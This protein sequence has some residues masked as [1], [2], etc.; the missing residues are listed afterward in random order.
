M[1]WKLLQ[2]ALATSGSGTLA[3]LIGNVLSAVGVRR[4][5]SSVDPQQSVRFTVAIVALAA[6]LSKA[7]GVSTRIEAEVFHRLFRIA[8]ADQPAVERLFNLAKQDT[9]G[10]ESY[11][12]KIG[13]LLGDD[14]DLKRDVLENLFVIAAAD[15]VLHHAEDRFLA[16]VANRI[17]MSAAELASVRARY[18]LDDADP[19]VVLGV[20]RGDSPSV[21]RARYLWLVKHYHPDLLASRGLPLGAIERATDKLAAIN[22]AYA[23]ITRE[24]VS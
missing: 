21:I 9:S 16:T 15:E 19:Y 10:F 23:A 14:A 8:E 6:K 24:T 22:D 17:G 13:Q 3:T 7:D 5:P 2:S 4:G 1:P 18:V 20:E 11:A 12:D